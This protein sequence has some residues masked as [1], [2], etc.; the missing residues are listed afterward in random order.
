LV[1]T[2][3]AEYVLPLRWS[4]DSG[5]DELSRYLKQLCRWID[6]TVVDGS[7]DPL[8]ESHRRAWPDQVR[9][10]RPEAWPGA[11]G[12]VAGVMTGI[13]HARHERVVLAD[14]DIRYGVEDLR[15]VVD[16]LSTYDLVRPTNYYRELPWWAR[17]DTARTL[18]NRAFGA[19]YPGTLGVRRSIV[20]RAGGYSGEVLFENLELIRTVK[21]AGGMERIAH[22]L[23]VARMPPTGGHF[24]GQRV[25]QAYDDF[26]QP[27]RLLL[28]LSLLPLLGWALRRPRR[29]CGLGMAI[30]ALAEMGRR[31]AGGVAVYPASTVLWAPLWV[32]ER[33]ICIWLAVGYRRRGVPYAG[34]RLRSAGTS[35]RVL[36]RRLKNQRAG[37]QAPPTPDSGQA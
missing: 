22:D 7:A 17:W 15:E 36:T 21:A 25:R 9:H 14:D 6:V 26:A 35:Q 24:W 19:D 29:L 12:K 32:M 23:Y 4:D 2:L 20:E 1:Q 16:L 8:F 11:N 18:L 10:L 31:R 5:L 28:E 30:C 34:G 3:A 37:G 13:R 33:A 27:G